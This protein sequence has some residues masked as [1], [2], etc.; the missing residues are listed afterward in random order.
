MLLAYAAP[1]IPGCCYSRFSFDL[2]RNNLLRGEIWG[3]TVAADD[4]SAGILKES[5]DVRMSLLGWRCVE[6]GQTCMGKQ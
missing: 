4:V 5:E 2:C 1:A 3:I 6:S